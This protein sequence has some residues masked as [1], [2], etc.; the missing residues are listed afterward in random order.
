[1]ND[2]SPSLL[3]SHLPPQKCAEGTFRAVSLLVGVFFFPDMFEATLLESCVCIHLEF[4]LPSIA[5]Q[6]QMLGGSL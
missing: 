1:M 6:L 5:L 4:A 2:A 3:H